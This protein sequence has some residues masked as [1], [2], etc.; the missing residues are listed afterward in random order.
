MRA[1]SARPRWFAPHDL[2]RARS[3]VLRAVT[4]AEPGRGVGAGALARMTT[5]E[6]PAV[7]AVLDD[8]LAEGAVTERNG[9]FAAAGAAHALDDPLAQRLAEL[10]RAD[11]VAPRAPDALADAAGVDRPAALRSLDRLAAEGVLVRLRPG[12]YFDPGALAGARAAVVS[13]CERDGSITIAALRD[14]LGT[15]RKHAQAILEH[16]DQTRVTRRRGDE[17]VLRARNI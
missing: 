3:G 8:L 9:V 15:S 5:L 2:E 10:V 7:R 17:H 13:A 16:L 12:V 11:G 6:M 4:A 1:G 14:A